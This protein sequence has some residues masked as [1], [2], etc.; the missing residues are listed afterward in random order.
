MH[1]SLSRLTSK[2]LPRFVKFP[3]LLIPVHKG[4]QCL[5]ARRIWVDD[6]DGIYKG[7]KISLVDTRSRIHESTVAKELHHSKSKTRRKTRGRNT[8][9]LKRK[10]VPTSLACTKTIAP[11]LL[12]YPSDM[13]DDYTVDTNIT[14]STSKKGRQSGTNKNHIGHKVIC[15]YR[16]E[17]EPGAKNP[18]YDGQVTYMHDSNNEKGNNDNKKKIEYDDAKSDISDEYLDSSL[19]NIT[20]IYKYTDEDSIAETD[21]GDYLDYISRKISSNS[22]KIEI[23]NF[24]KICD[25]VFDK[26]SDILY[27]TIL[28][29]Y[30]ANSRM[31]SS[32][33][34]LKRI[35][36]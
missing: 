21:Y 32:T 30:N 9:D 33:T 16:T 31:N 28:S 29:D 4:D 19:E 23:T 11:E 8:N 5:A 14:K 34:T 15:V 2:T 3:D 20:P 12:A 36:E 18:Y 10:C 6:D 24:M 27:N 25:L 26:F 22:L 1:K 35:D 17:I 7:N 13:Y